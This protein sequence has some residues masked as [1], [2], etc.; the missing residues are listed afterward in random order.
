M[1]STN[2]CR[3]VSGRIWSSASSDSIWAMTI[4]GMNRARSSWWNGSSST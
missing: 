3:A 1:S 4:S 2:R